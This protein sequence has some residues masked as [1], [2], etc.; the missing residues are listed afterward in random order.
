MHLIQLLLPIYDNR[1]NRFPPSHHKAVKDELARRFGG[2]T[3]YTQ[4]PAEGL[5]S[6]DR[7][8]QTRDDI[9]VYEVMTDIVDPQWWRAFR[10]RLELQFEQREV[11]VRALSVTKL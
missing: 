2:L 8:V 6:D 11:L 9:I 3:A 7:G 5:W 10:E 1:G 4:A